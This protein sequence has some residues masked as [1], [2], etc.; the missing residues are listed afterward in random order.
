MRSPGNSRSTLNEFTATT[1][2]NTH[3]TQ[4][5][6]SS[7]R[8][9]NAQRQSVQPP[10]HAHTH[11]TRSLPGVISTPLS[12]SARSTLTRS[13]DTRTHSHITPSQP[14]TRMRL[15]AYS[16]WNASSA[17]R[18]TLPPS[19][20]PDRSSS[21]APTR[22]A[23]QVYCFRSHGPF[24]STPLAL[25]SSTSPA[26]ARAQHIELLEGGEAAEMATIRQRGE[27]A[28]EGPPATSHIDRREGGE[29][30]EE[31]FRQRGEAICSSPILI[32]VRGRCS[33]GVLIDVREAAPATR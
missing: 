25:S 16:R 1:P 12:L 21:I 31:A 26:T 7:R 27:A 3:I 2:R 30:A 5:T 9:L 15:S 14:H 10:L 17:S 8:M 19:A 4:H 13:T 23:A 24:T 33:C 20:S 32:D 29:A 18:T 11:S 28:E 22:G 6:R